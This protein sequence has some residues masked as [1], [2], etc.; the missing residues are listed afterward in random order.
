MMEVELTKKYES[1]ECSSS[2]IV[3]FDHQMLKKVFV[4]AGTIRFVIESNGHEI[5]KFFI[6]ER[7]T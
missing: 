3:V 4:G 6:V 2:L 1:L 7:L 5:L